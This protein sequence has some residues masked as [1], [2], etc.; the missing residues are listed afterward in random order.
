MKLRFDAHACSYTGQN[1]SLSC[2]RAAKMNEGM[3]GKSAHAGMDML[4]C[5]VP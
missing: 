5:N 1:V 3:P 2:W 4:L